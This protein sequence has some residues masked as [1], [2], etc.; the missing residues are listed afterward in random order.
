MV[1]TVNEQTRDDEG[2]FN[3]RNFIVKIRVVA[4]EIDVKSGRG[5]ASSTC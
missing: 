4:A 3:E 1:Y 5:S 2:A